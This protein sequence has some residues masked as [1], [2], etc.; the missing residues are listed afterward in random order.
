MIV[1]GLV[2]ELFKAGELEYFS[3]VHSVDG[4]ANL[5]T[6]SIR[7]LRLAEMNPDSIKVMAF[8]SSAKARDVKRI[9]QDYCSRLDTRRLADY[10]TCIHLVKNGILGR[11]IELPEALVVI[12]PEELKLAVAEQRLLDSMS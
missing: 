5:M 11:S 1:H 3:R 8:E 4:L 9:F 10:A 7:D 12:Q 6:K 2:S